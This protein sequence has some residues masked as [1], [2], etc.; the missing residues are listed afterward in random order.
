MSNQGAGLKAGEARGRLRELARVF[1][2]LGVAAFGGPAT[3]IAMMREEVVDR[4]GW[5]DD[6][7]FLDLVGATNLIPGPNSTEMAIHVGYER[8]GKAGLVVAGVSFMLPAVA[9]VLVLAW[10]YVEYG[11]LP[12]AGWLLYGVKPVVVALI[13]HALWVLG[14]QAVKGLLTGAVGVAVLAL[15]LLGFNEIALLFAGGAVVA[16]VR[17]RWPADRDV[18][19]E[20]EPEPPEE[21]PTPRRRW[22]LVAAVTLAVGLLAILVVVSST[23]VRPPVGLDILFL[24]F[25]KIGSVLYGSGYVLLA[26]LRADFVVRFGWLTDTQLLDA[27]AIGQVT[28]GPVFTTA[29]FIG[30]VVAGWPGALVATL[31]IFLPSFLL[32]LLIHPYVARLRRSPRASTFLDGVNVAA[33]GLMAGV[34]LQLGAVAVVDPVTVLLLAGTLVALLRFRVDPALLVLL[35]ALVGLAAGFAGLVP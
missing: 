32:V 16:A 10:A 12:E 29:T 21:R 28:P 15:Y 23:W 1:L 4:R 24:T 11:A 33:I 6:Q 8:G 3:H 13:A 26:L 7:R 22:A 34:A 20:P 9:I 17:W 2:R 30:Y 25:L 14:R 27:V 18:G 19:R 5:M 35:G 31:G